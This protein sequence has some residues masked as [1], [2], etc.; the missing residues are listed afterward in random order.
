M[1]TDQMFKDKTLW[2]MS[3]CFLA[4]LF[5]FCG[6]VKYNPLAR[7]DKFN[8]KCSPVCLHDHTLK[9]DHFAYAGLFLKYMQASPTLTLS[10]SKPHNNFPLLSRRKEK[11]PNAWWH[12]LVNSTASLHSEPAAPVKGWENPLQVSEHT[13]NALWRN[14]V[15]TS[16]ETQLD[17]IPFLSFLGLTRPSGSYLTLSPPSR[18]HLGI[19]S[20]RKLST[21]CPIPWHVTLFFF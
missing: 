14:Q 19:I 6:K 11:L 4:T 8:R 16:A 18:L 5:H 12:F 17:T 2:Q 10:C 20:S 15:A 7:R 21:L 13:L 9:C 3:V 1:Q